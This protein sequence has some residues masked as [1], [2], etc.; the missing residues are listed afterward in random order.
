MDICKQGQ[1]DVNQI[2]DIANDK[3]YT[4]TSVMGLALE[5]F[6]NLSFPNRV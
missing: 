1:F 3:G 6:I 5:D 2:I 4:F